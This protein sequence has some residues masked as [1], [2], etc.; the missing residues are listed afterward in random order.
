MLCVATPVFQNWDM[1]NYTLLLL[2]W[3]CQ[4]LQ[5]QHNQ[6]MVLN[7]SSARASGK[8]L[9]FIPALHNI[10]KICGNNMY[11]P[12]SLPLFSWINIL[13]SKH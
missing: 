5:Y 3:V 4:V 9:Y 6:S 1:G 11:C 13:N 10:F 12:I 2:G 7:Y 8:G